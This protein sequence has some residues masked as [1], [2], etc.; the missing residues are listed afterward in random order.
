MKTVQ[1]TI[2]TLQTLWMILL[3]YEQGGDML[4]LCARAES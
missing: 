2:P 4:E 3:D 1:T